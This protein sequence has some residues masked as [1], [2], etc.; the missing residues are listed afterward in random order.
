[1]NFNDIQEAWNREEREENELKLNLAALKEAHQP[2][3]SLRKNMRNELYM[4]VAAIIF[5]AFAPFYYGIT[6]KLLMAYFTFY[7]LLVAVSGA[8]F[9]RFFLFFRKIHHYNASAKDNLYELYYEIRLHCEMYK[10]LTYLLL[11]FA[12]VMRGI[13]G[14]TS[15]L[16]KFPDEPM[17][18]GD[19]DWLIF[20]VL[21]LVITLIYISFT[22]LWVNHFYGKHAKSIRKILD[23]LKE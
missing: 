15:R 8:Y 14:Y 21:S 17:F 3:D 7:G 12:L 20:S 10:S 4:Q 23:E 9:Y 16:K 22:N 19:T 18:T 1:M 11:P 2:I 5:F 6:G 13:I